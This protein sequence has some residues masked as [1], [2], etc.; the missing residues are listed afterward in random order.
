M[1]YLFGLLN[2]SL[3][4][5]AKISTTHAFINH[6]SSNLMDIFPLPLEVTWL[7]VHAYR[8]FFHHQ[9]C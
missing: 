4:A 3:P 5:C 8:I 9:F 7:M 1:G 6:S 2:L